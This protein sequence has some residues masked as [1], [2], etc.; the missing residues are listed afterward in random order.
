MDMA[1]QNFYRVGQVGKQ[2]GLSSYKIRRLAESGLIPDAEFSG[3]QWHIPVAA[4]ERMKKEGVPPLPKVVDTDHEGGSPSA[5][6]KD[7]APTTL[8]AEPSD[9]MVRAAE[10]AEMS[11]RQLT[12]AKKSAGAEARASGGSGDR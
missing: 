5:N 11:G 2:L 1:K 4:V 9:E 10:E 12:V 8:L 6:P 7:R 3:S